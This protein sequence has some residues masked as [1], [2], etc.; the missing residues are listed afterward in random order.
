MSREEERPE[1]AAS[2]DSRPPRRG[3]ATALVIFLL[4]AIPAGYLVISAMQSR[5]SG[6]DKSE[7]ASATGL[8]EGWPTRV[9]RRIYDVWIPPYSADVAFYETNSWDTSA[10]YVQF[11]TSAEGLDKFLATLDTDRSALR[12]GRI[13]VDA[14]HAKKVGWRLGPGKD[15]AGLEVDQKD[16][17]PTLDITVDL[18]NPR[19]PEVYLVSTVTP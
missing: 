10:M 17:E 12:Q 2:A 5:S 19:H 9:Q 4:I 13:T 15:W 14:E 1:P 3:W 18:G 11:I 6:E 7:S 8:T 16:P